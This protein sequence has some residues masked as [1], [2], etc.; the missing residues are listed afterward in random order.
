MN[1]KD[2]VEQMLIETEAR[3]DSDMFAFF[4]EY[5]NARELKEFMI[6]MNKRKEERKLRREV[7]IDKYENSR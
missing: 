2:L 1:D 3:H 7:L 5:G 4:K 6:G